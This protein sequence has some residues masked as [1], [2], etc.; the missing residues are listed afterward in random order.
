MEQ[1]ST[2]TEIALE[3]MYSSLARLCDELLERDN[4]VEGDLL[5]DVFLRKV[6]MTHV[7]GLMGIYGLWRDQRIRQGI[8]EDD[9]TRTESLHCFCTDKSK[10]L[11]LWGEFAIPQFLAHI[12]FHRS[13]DESA[14]NDSYYGLVESIVQKNS[15]EAGGLLF[16][17][18]Y[19]A[20]SFIQH[21]CKLVQE[22]LK[23][24]F[25]E[26]S[27]FIEGLLH[28]LIREDQKELTHAVFPAVTHIARNEYVPG[29]PWKFFFYRDRSGKNYHRL[30]N[31]PCGW[32]ELK[33]EASEDEGNDLPETLK[34]FPLGYLCLL[35]VYP[36]RV[37]SSG[38]R[39]IHKQLAE[40]KSVS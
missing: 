30:W 39:W 27:Y 5:S 40:K 26:S 23:D 4:F 12:F 8:E 16:N 22:P 34:K 6:R 17:P 2:I 13:F 35:C 37:S 9:A 33:A 15:R 29:S 1:F 28:L 21:M 3:A 18:Y 14:K 31:F 7:L 24:S 36:H 19:D 25:E 20:E 38:L 10:L 11:F 32:N